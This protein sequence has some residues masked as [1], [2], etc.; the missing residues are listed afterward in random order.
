MC[1]NVGSKVFVLPTTGSCL[2]NCQYDPGEAAVPFIL[3]TPRSHSAV[4]VD[5]TQNLSDAAEITWMGAIS[6][7]RM[8][9]C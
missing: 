2:V 4:S 1:S 7:I 3:P 8:G 9:A 6:V 5:F